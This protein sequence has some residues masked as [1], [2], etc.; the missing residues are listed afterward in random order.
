[1]ICADSKTLFRTSDGALQFGSSGSAPLCLTL[2]RGLRPGL[3]RVYS[4]RQTAGEWTHAIHRTTQAV[5]DR[6]LASRGMDVPGSE[7][8]SDRK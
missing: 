1:M 6:A 4:F 5:F 8:D 3:S 2:L 7:E